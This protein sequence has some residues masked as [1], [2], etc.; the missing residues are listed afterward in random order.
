VEL[1]SDTNR[2]EARSPKGTPGVENKRNEILLVLAALVLSLAA[3]E[4]FLRYF[5]PQL[6]EHDHM[7]EY[8]PVLGWTFVPNKSGVILFGREVRQNIHTNSWG[9]RDNSPPSQADGF[10]KILVMGDSFVSNISVNDSEVFTEVMESRLKNG[11]VLNF[12]VNGYG[13]VQEYLL[14]Q[15]WLDRVHPQL[16]ILVIYLRNDFQD[17]LGVEWVYPRP[18]MTWDDQHSV[19]TIQPPPPAPSPAA[20]PFYRF[21][22]RSHFYQ[23]F[24][25]GAKGLAGGSGLN[26]E[27]PMPS[28]WTPPEWY[29]CRTSPSDETKLMFQTMQELML[30]ISAFVKERGIPLVFV[31]A[32]STVQVEDEMWYSTIRSSGEKAEAFSRLLPNE[33]LIEFGN[34]ND[35]LI[36]DLSPALIS[37]SKETQLYNR[38]DQH[39]NKDGNR[40]V[41]ESLMTFLRDKALIWN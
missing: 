15:R 13:Q 2:A 28:G 6:T 19:A 14:L 9:F 21:Y 25:Q 39:W 11:A 27:E 26:Y 31:L 3:S 16:V 29:L 22:R 10:K 40:V 24:R 18:V 23:L 8:D 17:N 36:H 38:T 5:Y 7:F 4:V 33:E 41:A 34:G 37:A 20:T 35:L 1:K 30:K 32:P 12:G